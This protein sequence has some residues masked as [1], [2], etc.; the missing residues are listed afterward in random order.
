MSSNEYP[1]LLYYFLDR[2][3]VNIES[4]FRLLSLY[5][6]ASKNPMYTARAILIM[7][8]GCD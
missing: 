6:L 1:L 4:I 2:L 7:Y 8:I 5:K 3:D